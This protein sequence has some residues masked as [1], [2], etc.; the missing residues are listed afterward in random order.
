MK[1]SYYSNNIATFQNDDNSK[2][3]GALA[4]NHSHALEDLQK[5]AWIRQIEILKIALQNVEDGQIY[6]EFSIPRMGKR[7]DNVLII[8]DLIFVLEFKV[9]EST[10]PKYAI[11]QAVDYSLDLK[12]FYEGSHH[13]KILPVLIATKA[14]SVMNV[15][16][17][18][19]SMFESI[20]TNEQ[21]LGAVIQQA[22]QF[23]GETHL[24]PDRSSARIISWS[25]CSRNFEA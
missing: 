4:Q 1:R 2:I 16:T 9:G 15:F 5:N 19:D 18:T 25:Q 11:E 3:L 8:K 14:P 20:L 6:F 24:N 22:L 12:N 21:D 23:A 10:Y 13:Q 17:Q 7:V